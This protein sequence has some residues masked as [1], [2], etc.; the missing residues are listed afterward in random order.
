MGPLVFSTIHSINDIVSNNTCSVNKGYD[1]TGHD[2]G[3]Q[4]NV[5]SPEK[6]CDLCSSFEKCSFWAWNNYEGGT[7][8]FKESKGDA[9][10]RSTVCWGTS[11]NKNR[12]SIKILQYNLQGWN[13]LGQHPDTL[14]KALVKYMSHVA[15]DFI[16][17]EETLGHSQ[18]IK[19]RLPGYDTF[20]DEKEGVSIFYKN[21]TWKA[22]NWGYL[23]LPGRDQ[24]G[25]R[26]LRYNI[27]RHIVSGKH[28]VFFTTHWCVCS[29]D[30]LLGTARFTADALAH[31][32]PAGYGAILTG[33][34]NVFQKF[35]KSKAVLFM[36]GQYGVN[37]F[38][39]R[40]TF[41]DVDPH[42]PGSTFG[43]AG[44]VD[45]IFRSSLL[46]TTKAFIDRKTTISDHY[47]VTA[48]VLF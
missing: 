42:G 41:R 13:T 18:W 14:G 33:D 30:T 20:G 9:V 28:I 16:G 21:A 45:Y 8:W 1:L 29:D 10:P 3:S 7:C 19:D 27:F 11:T 2:V 46:T 36:K 38:P 24:W 15:P 31:I 47:P 4:Y 37:P 40:D 6:C 39:L 43:A 35:E 44:K 22:E 23:N 25:Q 17:T 26:V 48:E 34:L 32:V 12:I 5:R